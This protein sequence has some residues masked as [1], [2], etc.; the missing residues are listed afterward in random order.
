M[1][2]PLTA[3][4]NPLTVLQSQ[5]AAQGGG[6]AQASQ[7]LQGGQA[8]LNRS[9]QYIEK[10]TEG[11][12]EEVERRAE[13]Y[14]LKIERLEGEVNDWIDVRTE[15]AQGRAAATNGQDALKTVDDKLTEMRRSLLKYKETGSDLYK[16]QYFNALR[17][18][19]VAVGG[20]SDEYNLT[21]Q[22]NKITHEP[23]TISYTND[24]TNGETELRGVYAGTG[25]YVDVSQKNGSAH[26]STWVADMDILTMTEYSTYDADE[27]EKSDETG[28]SGSLKNGFTLNTDPGTIDY[29]SDSVT[30]Q[31]THESSGNTFTGTV[32]RGGLSVM[33]GWFYGG[34]TDGSGNPNGAAIDRALDDIGQAK[35]ELGGLQAIMDNNVTK[36]EN[37]QNQADRAVEQ[38]REEIS[39]T[40]TDKAVAVRAFQQH[41][42]AEIE[43]MR[44]SL[45]AAQ[46]SSSYTRIFQGF[47]NSSNNPLFISANI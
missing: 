26:D 42:Q 5:R 3:T 16:D 29:D 30:I 19:N 9:Q 13:P 41:E 18:L 20:A 21:G 28:L 1:V 14:D 2:N 22:Q 33:P 7:I 45:E 27:P 31:F 12:K 36:V 17:E 23:N 8:S 32:E 4:G 35:N 38:L 25:F 6:T 40:R 46:Q 43:D 34:F 10:A 11:L 39:Q 15:I 47:V 24:R 37:D 44:Q